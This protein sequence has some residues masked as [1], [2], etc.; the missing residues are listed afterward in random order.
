MFIFLLNYWWSISYV[1]QF[2]Y[3]WKLQRYLLFDLTISAL[4]FFYRYSFGYNKWYTDSNS[5]YCILLYQNNWEKNLIGPSIGNQ[6]NKLPYASLIK[7]YAVQRR[8]ALQSDT[9]RCPEYIV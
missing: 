3:I 4:Q 2:G 7:Y 8:V 9:E 6:S 1:V 5:Y